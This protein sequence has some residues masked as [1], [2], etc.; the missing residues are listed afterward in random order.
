MPSATNDSLKI[1]LPPDA[2]EPG[3]RFHRSSSRSKQS[4]TPGLQSIG[5]ELGDRRAA[6]IEVSSKILPGSEL[7]HRG[8]IGEVFERV[9]DSGLITIRPDAIEQ[10][11]CLTVDPATDVIIAG[12]ERLLKVINVLAQHPSYRKEGYKRNNNT[13][14]YY[15]G[16]KKG[17]YAGKAKVYDKFAED[18]DGYFAPDTVRFELSCPTSQAIQH[19]YGV[20][21]NRQG[22][23]L[24]KDVLDSPANPVADNFEQILGSLYTAKEVAPMQITRS[25]MGT[26]VNKDK[27]FRLSLGT[28]REMHLFNMLLTQGFDLEEV[29]RTLKPTFKDRRPGKKA[30]LTPYANMLQ[31]YSSYDEELTLDYE[32]LMTLRDLLRNQSLNQS[33]EEAF[34]IAA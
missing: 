32:V 34:A 22:R 12:S 4:R 19:R 2:V 21:A 14:F 15:T 6:V 9:N 7:I 18:K 31:R 33:Q 5:S 29:Y 23:V 8:N 17:K 1:L 20:G 11:Y 28:A 25:G 27:V 24:L 16:S 13:T 3:F 30:V 26:G 10:A